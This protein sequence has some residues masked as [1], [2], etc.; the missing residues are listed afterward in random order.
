MEAQ[1][2]M[3]DELESDH[4]SL[5]LLQKPGIIVEEVRLHDGGEVLGLSAL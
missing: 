3:R 4:E 1:A 2:I 5:E